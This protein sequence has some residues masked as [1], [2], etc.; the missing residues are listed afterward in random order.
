M[1]TRLILL[2]AA[3]LAL[4]MFVAA[5]GGDDDDGGNSAATAA[6]GS[7]DADSA[8]GAAGNEEQPDGGSED[9]SGEEL[10]QT[11]LSK[12]AYTEK[13]DQICR[14][15]ALEAVSTLPPPSAGKAALSE[16][17]AEQVVPA[18]RGVVTGL[19]ELGAPKGDATQIEALLE[20]LESDIDDVE[21]ESGSIVNVPQLAQ[22][23]GDSGKLAGKYGL[24]HCNYDK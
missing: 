3:C 6:N 18:L 1:K 11:S 12:A 13:A 7:A 4:A 20:A 9:A 5:C 19:A 10:S 16:S 2:V 8:A 23:F 22:R 21:A 17:V 14:A 15:G 24:P